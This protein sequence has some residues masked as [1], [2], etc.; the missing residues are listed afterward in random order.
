VKLGD[1]IIPDLVRLADA[2]EDAKAAV[3]K[4][5]AQGVPQHARV[6]QEQQGSSVSD[7]L[8][9]FLRNIAWRIEMVTFL[10]ETALPIEQR[11][12]GVKKIQKR[13]PL[14]DFISKPE[15]AATF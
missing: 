1:V 7:K 9:H 5:R 11:F 15:H 4:C 14:S 10:Q 13:G 8:G 2:L 12:E 6:A 3:L